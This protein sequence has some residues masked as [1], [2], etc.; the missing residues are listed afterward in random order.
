MKKIVSQR[1][2]ERFFPQRKNK[3]MFVSSK[4]D[5][6]FIVMSRGD[7]RKQFQRR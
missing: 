2:W 3:S 6:E 4:K 7:G 5:K 1:E